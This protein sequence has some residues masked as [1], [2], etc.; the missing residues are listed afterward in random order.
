[1]EDGAMIASKVTAATLT[2][3]AEEIGVRAEIDTQSARGTRHRVK[4]FPIVLITS[5]RPSGTRYPDER[6]DSKYQRTSASCFHDGR[7]VNAV[8]W[9]GFRDFFRAVYRREPEAV[10]YTAMATWRG[11]VHFEANFRDSGHRNIGSQMYPRAAAE[12]CRCPESGYVD[13]DS[14]AAPLVVERIVRSLWEVNPALSAPYREVHTNPVDTYGADEA[15]G[16]AVPRDGER[17]P[18]GGTVSHVSTEDW[19]TVFVQ[20]RRAARQLPHVRGNGLGD[21]LCRDTGS[22]QPRV[23]VCGDGTDVGQR[24]APSGFGPVCLDGGSL[25]RT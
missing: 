2:A 7:R 22:T 6:G 10:F 16:A 13:T 24:R 1:M 25:R 18:L 3:A 11:S 4:L 15:D 23:T 5:R 21:R 20:A 8:C 12:C 19:R 14:S 9:H 17:A